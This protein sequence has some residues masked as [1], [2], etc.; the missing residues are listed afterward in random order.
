M[1]I[2]GLRGDL[3]VRFAPNGGAVPGDRIVAI[4]TPAKHHHLSD[5]VARSDRLR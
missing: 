1:P 3:P 5:P 2:Y 4:L